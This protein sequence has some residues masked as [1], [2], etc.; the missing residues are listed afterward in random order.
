MREMIRV[1]F[2]DDEMLVKLGLRSVIDWNQEGFEI[3]GEASNGQEGLQLIKTLQPDLV[4]SDIVMP[5]MDGIEMYQKLREEGIDP[6]FIVLSS[7]DQF[8]MVKRAMK[9]GA[10]DYLLKLSLNTQAM[11]ELLQE[12]REE[13]E[14][15]IKGNSRQTG[16]IDTASEGFSD[17]LELNRIYL[18]GLL[19]GEKVNPNYLQHCFV[20]TGGRNR[21]LYIA[22]DAAHLMIS[23]SETERKTYIRTIRSLLDEIA[24]EF[25]EAYCIEWENSN[26]VIILEAFLPES[27]F[28]EIAEAITASLDN[29]GNLQSSIGIS[30][31]MELSDL[32]DAYKMARR[33]GEDLTYNGYG[34]IRFYQDVG[35]EHP[36]EDYERQ[37][38]LLDLDRLRSICEILNAGDLLQYFN[39][40][41]FAVK[42]HRLSLEET[43]FQSVQLIC[44][45]E[46]Y[47]KQNWSDISFEHDAGSVLAQI[48]SCQ[49]VKE[50]IRCNRD[51]V[52]AVER[53]AQEL[54]CSDGIRLVRDAKNYIRTHIS[55]PIGLAEIADALKVS[56]SYL[57]ATFSQSESMGLINYINKEKVKRA[58]YMMTSEHL[59]VYE[60]SYMLGFENAGYFSKV[61]KKY[62]GC[63]PKQFASRKCIVRS[64]TAGSAEPNGRDVFPGDRT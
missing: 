11:H 56:S 57:S 18:Y 43:S 17:Q 7:Y 24:S 15:K 49:S 42:S 34:T 3:V 37:S 9:A 29:Y 60:V 6:I 28:R 47:L 64:E 1:V 16:R 54:F 22:T 44:V 27:T 40:F 51:Y 31:P 19:L 14:E 35:Q 41:N 39:E 52:N 62:A 48:Y 26:Y 30:A 46:E 33:I 61:F 63:T 25:G 53:T 23:K 45:T 13:I 50:I 8:D 58:Q 38:N 5:G 59:K 55:D 20:K 36:I 2:V 12:I 4:I 21:V 32:Q 10:R